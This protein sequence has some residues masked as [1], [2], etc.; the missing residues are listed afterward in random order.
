MPKLG[1]FK[2]EQII[3]EVV[4]RKLSDKFEALELECKEKVVSIITDSCKG[5]PIKACKG[6]INYGR[7]VEISREGIGRDQKR[8]NGFNFTLSP[9]LPSKTGSY[10]NFYPKDGKWVESLIKKKEKLNDQ[11]EVIESTLSAV[12]NSCSTEKH[13][14]ETL[15]E[16]EPIYNDLF[17]S[18]ENVSLV[19]VE[20]IEKAKKL[21]GGL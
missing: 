12:L 3:K 17:K 19:A 6:Y 9:S 13:L 15:P 1:K 11:K 16:L 4:S 2:K 18:R 21:L 20:T 5:I 14:F 10:F 7:Y 8:K